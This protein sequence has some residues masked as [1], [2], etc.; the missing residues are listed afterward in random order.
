MKKLGTAA[1][2]AGWSLSELLLSP[3]T[4]AMAALAAT[5][6]GLAL[7]YR[8]ALALRMTDSGGAG[9]FSAL[10][11]GVYFPF[12]APMLSLVYASGVVR[13][14]LEASTLPY[15]LTRP[16]GRPSFLLGKM[17]ASY[18]MSVFLVHPSVVIV[19]YVVLAPSGFSGLGA[20]FPGLAR[21]LAVAAWGLVAYN[22]VFALAGTVLKRPLLAGLV[23]I[24]GWQAAATF[25]PGRARF[26]TVSH[27]MSSL[28]PGAPAAGILAAF[29]ERSHALTSIL[30]L[31]VIAGA[32]HALA[33]AA[34][35]NKEVR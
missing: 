9:V 15:F 22:G 8:V 34:F 11:S 31:A 7:A 33:I 21:S 1:L 2:V 13:D 4:F 18:A 19:Y 32:T 28:V 20:G 29:G 12:L 35:S 25:V 30:A 23:F 5:P 24:F 16:L 6:L 14:D 26:L 27:Y 17:A 3:R 10:V